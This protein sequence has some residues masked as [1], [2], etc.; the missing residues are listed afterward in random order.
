MACDNAAALKQKLCDERLANLV[1]REFE[2]VSIVQTAEGRTIA[3]G[4]KTFLL[5]CRRCCGAKPNK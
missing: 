3:D 5:P 1:P 4:V 2:V